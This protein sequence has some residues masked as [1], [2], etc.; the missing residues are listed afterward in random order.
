MYGVQHEVN[1]QW[2]GMALVTAFG[3]RTGLVK[4]RFCAYR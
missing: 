4:E 1:G 2:Y 3:T